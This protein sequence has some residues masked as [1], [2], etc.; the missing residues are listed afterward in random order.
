MGALTKTSAQ[1]RR[2]KLPGGGG[3]RQRSGGSVRAASTSGGARRIFTNPKAKGKK[4]RAPRPVFAVFAP[5][6]PRRHRRRRRGA[7]VVRSVP[8]YPALQIQWGRQCPRPLTAD[9]Y[10]LNVTPSWAIGCFMPRYYELR[11]IYGADAQAITQEMIVQETPQCHIVPVTAAE[12]ELQRRI[13]LAVAILLRRDG[14]AVDLPAL[15]TTPR[16]PEAS[17]IRQP[18]LRALLTG[19]I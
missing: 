8:L 9:C 16:P 6:R 5:V 17:R 11:R 1:P 10:A 12:Q 4:R 2:R 15:P 14:F 7:V 18:W 13:A 3:T 19:W